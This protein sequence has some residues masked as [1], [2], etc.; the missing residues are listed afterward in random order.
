MFFDGA[1]PFLIAGPCSAETRE[2]VLET[3]AGLQGLPIRLFRAGVWKPRTRPGH[4][5]G[6]GI[7][8]LEWLQEVKR[9]FGLPVTVE[10]AEPAHAEAALAHG[11]DVVWIGA[12]TTVNPFQVQ[13]LADALRGTGIPVMVKNPVTPDIELWIGAIERLQKAGITDIAAVH[14]GFT[15]YG[16]ASGY[17]NPPN[18]M[19][20]IELKRRR[21]DLPLFCDPSHISGDRKRVAETA[22][23]AMDMKF[24][25]LMIETHPNPEVAMSDAAQQITPAT[26]KTL[27]GNLTIRTEFSPNLS[28]M[29]QLDHYRQSIDNLDAELIDILAQRIRLSEEIGLMKKEHNLTVYQPGRWREIV[30]N[31]RNRASAKHLSP[32]FVVALFEKIHDEGVRI[33]LSLF[34]GAENEIIH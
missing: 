18:W 34:E 26:L 3:A 8:A 9:Q 23:K 31:C 29:A 32:D 12:R 33:Q 20:P 2:Q 6:R 7:P 21:P 24:D 19:I 11:V 10:I 22:Q 28:G 25:G 4:F 14:R 27:L 13:L 1:K 30:E 15:G 16:S 17:R 5:E